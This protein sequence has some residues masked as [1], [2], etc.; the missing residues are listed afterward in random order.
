[1]HPVISPD[2]HLLLTLLGVQEAWLGVYER[3]TMN[4]KTPLFL[5]P[6]ALI[7]AS[8]SGCATRSEVATIRT[9]VMEARRTADRALNVAEE[10]N[11]RSERTEEM[12]NRS[13]RHSMRK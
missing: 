11:R 7:A 10:A 12:V 2:A 8:S 1:M 3:L 6:L 13:Y 5:L 9:D 4:I